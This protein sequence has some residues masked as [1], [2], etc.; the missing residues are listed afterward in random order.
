MQAGRPYGIFIP[1]DC[2]DRVSIGVGLWDLG[3]PR[4]PSPQHLFSSTLPTPP[5]SPP[6]ELI[7]LES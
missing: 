3:Y 4:S 7:T 2:P 5:V 6:P 1:V